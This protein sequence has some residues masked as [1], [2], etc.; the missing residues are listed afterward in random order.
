MDYYPVK[1]KTI[2]FIS[3]NY[4]IVFIFVVC[5]VWWLNSSLQNYCSDEINSWESA[6]LSILIKWINVNKL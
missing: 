6:I 3:V 5:A 1:Q 2:S 4:I